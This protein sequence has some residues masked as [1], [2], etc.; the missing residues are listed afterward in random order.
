MVEFLRS[1]M[2]W[3]ADAIVWVQQFSNGVLD[4]VFT[5]AT[6]LGREQF[7][8][9]FLPIL[10]WCINKH[11]GRAL[12]IVFLLSEY[13]NG[14]LKD[15]FG[16]PRPNDF[17]PRIRA[18]LPETSPSFPSGHAQG[19]LVFWG[20]MATLVRRSWMWVVSIVLIVLISLSRIYLGVHF[21]QDI[22]GG[23][24]IGIV[25]GAVYLWVRRTVRGVI[26]SLGIQLGIALL[27]PP[28]L[29]ALHPSEGTA[30]I[31]GVAFGMLPGF[32]AEEHFVRFRADG[33][34]WK[35]VLRFIV[36][37]IPL[38]ALYLG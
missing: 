15:A 9:L 16:L 7:Y 26:L 27:V 2:T 19:S 12:S 36:G 14:I 20:T 31:T 35:R 24:V 6:Y 37:V 5:V 4:A 13:T 8:I 10:Y 21:P 11:L 22:L 25:L 17:D 33:V 1:L 23:W 30:L 34:W 3:G 28:I 32:V 38:L 29:F 18:P